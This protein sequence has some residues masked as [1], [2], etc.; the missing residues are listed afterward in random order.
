MFDVIQHEPSDYEV[1]TDWDGNVSIRRSDGASIPTDP[2]NKDYYEFL[3]VEKTDTKG[4]IKR[5]SI[6]KPASTVSQEDRIAKLEAD[7]LAAT[8]KITTLESKVTTDVKTG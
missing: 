4:E 8:A 3:Q 7:L 6:P 2:R 5:T 1:G